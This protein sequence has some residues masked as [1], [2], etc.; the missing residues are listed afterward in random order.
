MSLTIRDA[1][2]GDEALML[3]YIRMLAEHE[4]RPHLVTATEER[5]NKLFFAPDAFASAIVAEWDGAAVGHALFYMSISSYRAEPM[6]YLE[7]VV[8]DPAFRGK[9]IGTALMAEVAA[10]GVARGAVR[11][12]WSAL[13][14]NEDAVAMYEKI[15]AARRDGGLS[16]Y[17]QDDDLHTFAGTARSHG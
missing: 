11:M 8:V 10:R 16:F 5:L 9:R 15:G 4:G 17:F 1:A 2:P 3:K 12:H 7:D 6:V 14:D 13:D